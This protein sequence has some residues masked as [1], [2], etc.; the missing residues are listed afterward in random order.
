VSELAPTTKVIARGNACTVECVVCLSGEA[1]AAEFLESELALI[2]EKGKDDP[3]ATAR[4]RFMVLFQMMANYGRVSPKRFKK[5][6]GKLYAFRHEVK[7][8]RFASHVFR[9]ATNGS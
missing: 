6:M 9:T 2:R 7:N 1:P 3:Q 5:E 4:A 8:F